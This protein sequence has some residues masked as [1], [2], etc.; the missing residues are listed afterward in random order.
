ML[1]DVFTRMKKDHK[2]SRW[3]VV[4]V[5]GAVIV[6]SAGVWFY[7]KESQANLA[8]SVDQA[9]KQSQA[10]LAHVNDELKKEPA[11]LEE[12]RKQVERLEAELKKSNSRNDANV[13]AV[14]NELKEQRKKADDLD[15][16]FK[17]QK[18]AAAA[19]IPPPAAAPTYAPAPT[20]SSPAASPTV[21]ASTPPAS[22][23]PATQAATAN[24]PAGASFDSIA[25]KVRTMIDAGQ[26]VEALGLATQLVQTDPNRWEGY[27]LA[28]ETAQKLSDYSLAAD[29]YKKAVPKAP[30][31]MRAHL[32]DQ[33][34]R[35][36]E[37]VAK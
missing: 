12:A 19:Q 25:A 35:M 15:R 23:S 2:T 26:A 3:V 24:L 6:L 7:L 31:D 13:Q 20:A 8:A 28:G 10:D 37:K 16:A 9:T 27:A 11:A 18:A 34:R 30:A 1:G 4:T 14:L 22:V 29:M 33:A 36:Q 32:D 17:Q 5:L 21:A